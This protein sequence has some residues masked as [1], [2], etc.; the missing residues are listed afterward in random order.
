MNSIIDRAAAEPAFLQRLAEQPLAV[1]RAD[2]YDVSVT[3]L[4]DFL[5]L[6]ADSDERLQ[7]IVQIRLSQLAGGKW[8]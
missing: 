5:C 1:A 6:S 2:G 3:Q 7:E 8:I 4:L